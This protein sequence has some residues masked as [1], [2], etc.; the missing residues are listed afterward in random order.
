[1]Q[2]CADFSPASGAQK[3]SVAAID[4]DPGNELRNGT[5]TALTVSAPGNRPR[6]PQ[7]LTSLTLDGRPRLTWVA[8]LLDLLLQPEDVA[9]YRVYRDGT[10]VGY[11]DRYDRT[12]NGLITEYIDPDPGTTSHRYWVTTVNSKFNESNPIGPVTWSP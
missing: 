8:P 7:L 6:P 1:K 4:R 5:R 10:A 3:Y 2:S 12:A 9:F 11:A